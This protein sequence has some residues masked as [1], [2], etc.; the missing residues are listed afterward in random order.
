MES[1]IQVDYSVSNVVL[2]KV[3]V[4]FYPLAG[5]DEEF[6]MA[7]KNGDEKLA[8][9]AHKDGNE[10]GIILSDGNRIGVIYGLKNLK[11]IISKS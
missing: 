2:G 4:Y 9:I 3:N 5:I 1:I 10:Y 7:V 8:T 11:L 6:V